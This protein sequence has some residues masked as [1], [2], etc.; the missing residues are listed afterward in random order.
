[1]IKAGTD[2]IL[3]DLDSHQVYFP[4]MKYLMFLHD[5]TI[6]ALAGTIIAGYSGD[7][8]LAVSATLSFPT[9]VAAAGAVSLCFA[10]QGNNRVRKASPEGSQG[11][12]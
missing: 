2:I 9:G 5:G 4:K 7:G 8:G 10:D 11:V 1:M 12:Q 6:A 3:F